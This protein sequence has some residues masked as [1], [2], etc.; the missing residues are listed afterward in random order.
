MRPQTPIEVVLAGS[1]DNTEYVAE[2]KRAVAQQGLSD[3]FVFKGLLNETEVLDEFSRCAL[4]VLPSYQET[5]PMV[6]QQAMACGVPVV[7]TRICGVPDQVTDGVT[8][9]LYEPHDVKT[10]AGHLERLLKDG[11]L[12]AE[13]ATDGP[14]QSGA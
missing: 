8:G 2:V 13:M 7:A 11:D 12:R 3:C 9:L 6:I 10:L 14:G 1:L 5:A 4:L